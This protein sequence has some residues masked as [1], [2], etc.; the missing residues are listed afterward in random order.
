MADRTCQACRWLAVQPQ[1]FGGAD[2]ERCLNPRVELP[3]TAAGGAVRHPSPATA[4]YRSWMCGSLAQHF[5]PKAPV[6]AQVRAA[7]AKAAA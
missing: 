1:L 7:A 2:D 3:P 5:E 6:P 4:R